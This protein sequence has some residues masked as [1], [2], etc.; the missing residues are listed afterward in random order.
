[1]TLFW[2]FRYR[3]IDRLGIRRYVGKRFE[4]RGRVLH[5]FR[6]S[7]LKKRITPGGFSSA[8]L[9]GNCLPYLRW[10]TGKSR[11]GVR[12]PFNDCFHSTDEVRP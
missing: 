8:S 1:M 2:N 4:R 9:L 7:G 11:R 12:F 10:W 5:G 6:V 3:Q